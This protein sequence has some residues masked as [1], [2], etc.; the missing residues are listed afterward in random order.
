VLR[1]GVRKLVKRN[2]VKDCRREI[3]WLA[4]LIGAVER[5]AMSARGQIASSGD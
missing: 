3:G 2:I 4:E 5:I 1:D